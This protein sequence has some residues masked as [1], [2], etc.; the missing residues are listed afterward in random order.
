[1]ACTPCACFH[2]S[3]LLRNNSRKA[4]EDPM[5]KLFNFLGQVPFCKCKDGADPLLFVAYQCKREGLLQRI[6][7]EAY[8]RNANAPFFSIVSFCDCLHCLHRKLINN[9]WKIS[10]R[11]QTTRS[12]YLQKLI[13]TNG[14]ADGQFTFFTQ[15]VDNVTGHPCSELAQGYKQV[16]P[17]QILSLMAEA[18]KTH[19]VQS[20]LLNF[21]FLILEYWT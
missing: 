19:V 13:V 20:Y 1:V 9:D 21:A 14:T 15:A 18:N 17:H 6:K 12:A 2:G 3:A 16:H 10:L 4:F 11:S 7:D 8:E 5:K